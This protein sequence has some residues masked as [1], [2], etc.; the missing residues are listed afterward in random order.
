ME[1]NITMEEFAEIIESAD[2]IKINN[3][4]LNYNK[5]IEEFKKIFK[6]NYF[7]TATQINNLIYVQLLNN[8]LQETKLKIEIDPEDEITKGYEEMAKL[9]LEIAEDNLKAEELLGSVQ[10]WI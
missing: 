8:F 4:I 5:A 7:V 10:I 3:K 1:E 9:N 2:I 6:D